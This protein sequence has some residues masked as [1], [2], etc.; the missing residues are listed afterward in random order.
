MNRLGNVV[1]GVASHH[2]LA[3]DDR[4]GPHLELRDRRIGPGL[5]GGIESAEDFLFQFR[6]RIGSASFHRPGSF[7]RRARATGARR[8]RLSFQA[9]HDPLLDL[10]GLRHHRFSSSVVILRSRRTTLPSTT[11]V[12]T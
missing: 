8:P 11:T 5:R 6:I 9:L 7:A 1:L 2:N 3:V 10:A 4:R 12:F